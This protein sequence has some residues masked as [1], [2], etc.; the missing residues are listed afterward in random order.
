MA[1]TFAEKTSAA[2]KWVGFDY[3]YYYFIDK[4]LNM[5]TGDSLGLEVLD[6]VHA[7]VSSGFQ[8]LFQLK[9]TTALAAS[10][11]PVNLTSLDGDLW[12]TMSNWA[13][14]ISDKNDNRA[15]VAKQLEFVKK[16]EFH[17]VTNKTHSDSNLFVDAIVKLHAGQLEFD[18]VKKVVT[19]LHAATEDLNIKSY[20]KNVIS[21]E[22]KVAEKFFYQIRFELNSDE[23]LK[24]IRQSIAEKAIAPEQVDAVFETLDSNIREDNFI[25]IKLGVPLYISFDE[26]MTRYRKVFANGRKKSLKYI[27]YQ[28]VMPDDLM[29]QKF[30]KQLI[31]IGDVDTSEIEI[32]ADYTVK[33][34][35]AV[36]H[37]IE[38]HKTGQLIT[39]EIDFF[40]KDV[41]DKWANKFRRK[42][43]P[44]NMPSDVH[45][46]A[47]DLL[48]ELR[49]ITFL[50]DEQTLT[51]E[52]SNGELYNLSDTHRIGWH[53]NWDK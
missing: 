33:R 15:D 27:E 5:K 3:Q 22:S 37:L 44:E 6:D 34:M 47:I 21:L 39:T 23:I 24:K 18:D 10:G 40:H 9:H 31:H 1:K 41:I 46:A 25:N 14:L 12:K 8:L 45:G 35:R 51:T 48:D 17:L 50:L 30:V 49:E 52:L 11:K 53:P 28:P 32:V 16:S 36:R 19:S 13:E 42:F 2:D 26:F 43:R 38:W 29:T 7:K 20:I 4:L